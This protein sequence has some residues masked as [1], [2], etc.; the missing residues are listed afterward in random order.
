MRLLESLVRISVDISWGTTTGNGH[1]RPMGVWLLSD[2]NNNLK[3][4]PVFIDHYTMNKLYLYRFAQDLPAGL[5]LLYIFALPRFAL[6]GLLELLMVGLIIKW[7]WVDRLSLDIRLKRNLIILSSLVIISALIHFEAVS[8]LFNS[9]IYYRKLII[10]L[11][12]GCV[13]ARGLINLEKV[14]FYIATF[15]FINLIVS[16][17]M[18]TEVYIDNEI[19]VAFIEFWASHSLPSSVIENNTTQAII[20]SIALCFHSYKIVK[21]RQLTLFHLVIISLY[22]YF[23]FWESSSKSGY[24]FVAV[25]LL[26]V[27]W[28]YFRSRYG[29]LIGLLGSAL[30]LC[31]LS[32]GI[33]AHSPVGAKIDKV[34]SEVQNYNTETPG[35]NSQGMRVSMWLNTIE[36]IKYNWILGVGHSGFYNEYAAVAERYT[37]LRGT[38]SDDPHNQYLY[39]L[40]IYGFPMFL[41][42]IFV[43]VDL[44]KIS[45]EGLKVVGVI[46][47]AF[48]VVGLAANGI[49]FSF[50]E[51]RVFWL[52][53]GAAS[54]LTKSRHSSM[55][56]TSEN[57]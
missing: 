2:L 1:I 19:G 53:A 11:F 38:L 6:V 49:L 24:L 28:D 8:D 5:V 10:F 46:L 47:I 18:K 15:G 3:W 22:I 39:L 12:M 45:Y 29:Y 50:V 34:V 23:I 32:W 57:K 16:I 25:V 48:M 31:I 4:C 33:Y 35:G 37:G 30:L 56:S 26:V 20:F 44:V 51:G 55:R 52:L 27:F 21:N 54:G 40:A 14:L 36:I 41:V 13:V 9:I 42:W 43:L 7:I 17:I